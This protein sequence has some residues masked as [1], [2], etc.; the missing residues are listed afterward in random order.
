MTACT[1][2]MAVSVPAETGGASGR[3][4]AGWGPGVSAITAES[5]S[6]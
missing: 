3:M 1:T 4:P 5:T 2:L 6:G